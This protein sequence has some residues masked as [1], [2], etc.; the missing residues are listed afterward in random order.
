MC[1]LCTADGTV[2][3]KYEAIQREISKAWRV[4][5]K[6]RAPGSPSQLEEPGPYLAGPL[7]G[8][9]RPPRPALPPRSYFLPSGSGAD[10]DVALDSGRR[11]RGVTYLPLTFEYR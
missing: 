10:Y 4:W 5:A 2:G 11:C 1:Y 6:S 9:D 3:P 8:L 7:N